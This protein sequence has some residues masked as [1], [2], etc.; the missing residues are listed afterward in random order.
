MKTTLHTPTWAR[1][2]IGI[3]A[4][5]IAAY[6]ALSVITQHFTGRARSGAIV[7]SVGGFAV[8]M[9]V[10]FFGVAILMAS[11]ILP[12]RWRHASIIAGSVVMVSGIVSALVLK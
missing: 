7:E 8:G 2:A 12:N 3:I 9:G 1:I 10:F 5:C 4:A 6:G 11:L